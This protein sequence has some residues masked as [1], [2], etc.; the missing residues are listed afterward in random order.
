MCTVVNVAVMNKPNGTKKNI[1]SDGNTKKASDVE[2]AAA[3]ANNYNN[4]NDNNNDNGA[5][6]YEE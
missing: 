6:D 3:A 4:D 2:A 5:G 1:V